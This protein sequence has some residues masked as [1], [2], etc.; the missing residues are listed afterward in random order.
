MYLNK[1]IVF[2]LRSEIIGCILA[3][4]VL[5]K[6]TFFEPSTIMFSSAK[7]YLYLRRDQLTVDYNKFLKNYEKK[8]IL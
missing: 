3:I 6:L 8:I 1:R 7:S 4:I 2:Y 5:N